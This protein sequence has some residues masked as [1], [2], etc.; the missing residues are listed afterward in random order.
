MT[1]LKLCPQ[2]YTSQP[3][4]ARVLFPG[5]QKRSS[6]LGRILSRWPSTYSAHGKLAHLCMAK[7]LGMQDAP[8]SLPTTL[9]SLL[10]H[11]LQAHTDT[12]GRCAS[13]PD[14][15]SENQVPFTTSGKNPKSTSRICQYKGNTPFSFPPRKWK[16][17][18][19][20]V[21]PCSRKSFSN[22][23]LL[24]MEAEGAGMQEEKSSYDIPK[25]VIQTWV[26]WLS[27]IWGHLA[28]C[29]FNWKY[30]ATGKVSF[31]ILLHVCHQ[32]SS[33]QQPYMASLLIR[34]TV[35]AITSK[36]QNSAA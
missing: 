25:K 15:W 28:P 2:K 31:K 4:S 33:S 29:G 8:P 3:L 12:V 10:N 5:K 17:K 18:R 7:W 23:N 6:L 34:V 35:V 32:I 16:K 19:Y 36:P 1:S 24:L 13:L 20:V 22:L 11:F 27:G 26:L 14:K 9:P 30:E 21:S